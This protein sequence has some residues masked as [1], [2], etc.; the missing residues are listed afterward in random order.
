MDLS[1]TST[2]VNLKRC[3]QWNSGS[4]I[5]VK[6][7]S[8][9]NGLD[10]AEYILSKELSFTSPR[11]INIPVIVIRAG[12]TIAD[13]MPPAEKSDHQIGSLDFPILNS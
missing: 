11:G 6:R 10:A 2:R 8:L 7:I 5:M 9:I 3:A 4:E 13:I 12:N 1:P